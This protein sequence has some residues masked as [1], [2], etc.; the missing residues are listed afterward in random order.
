MPSNF[1]AIFDACI[2]YPASLRDLLMQLALTDLFRARWTEKIHDEW[3]CNLLKNRSDL[4]LENLTRTRKL[5]DS[6]VRDC[7]V[8]GYEFLIPT[9]GLPDPGDRH[10]LAAAIRCGANVIVTA[11]LS[12]FP[13]TILS[14]HNVMAQHPDTFI[15]DLIDL[16]P[17]KVLA[18]AEIHRKRLKCPPTSVDT[19]LETLLKQ[20]LTISVC[21]LRELYDET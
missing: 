18:A 10:V 5:M 21:M 6:N 1:T 15:S 16:K 8:T 20:G 14:Q 13:E 19:Y 12:D 11:N 17:T 9:L 2:L 4:T 3:I 7:L